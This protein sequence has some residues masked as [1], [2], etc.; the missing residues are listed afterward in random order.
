MA[1]STGHQDHAKDRVY[2]DKLS[3]LDHFKTNIC[4]VIADTPPNMCKRVFENDL[5]RINATLSVDV[6]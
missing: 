5:K 1:I 2:A 6:I 3:T 4:Q